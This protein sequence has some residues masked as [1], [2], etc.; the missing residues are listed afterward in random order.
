MR[1]ED[2]EL[3]LELKRKARIRYA[4]AG[5]I[6]LAWMGFPLLVPETPYWTIVYILY[7]GLTLVGFSFFLIKAG[8]LWR[9]ARKLILSAEI[10]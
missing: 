7:S 2:W 4:I 5:V 10:E 3:Y 8:F 1:D 6:F 9:R